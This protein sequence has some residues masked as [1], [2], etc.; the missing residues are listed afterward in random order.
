MTF[1]HVHLR[2][3]KP[4]S[5]EYPA[6]IQT[7]GDH[8]RKHRL[9]LSLLQKQVAVQIGTDNSTVT[10]WE[11]GHTSPG[12]RHF[13]AIRRFLGYLPIPENGTL[14]HKLRTHRFIR[15]WSQ[16]EAARDLRVHPSTLAKWER[17]AVFAYQRPPPMLA[18]A[19]LAVPHQ[20]ER[21]RG[22]AAPTS[23]AK[24]VHDQHR[25]ARHLACRNAMV[26]RCAASCYR[27][28]NEWI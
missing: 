25:P 19:I 18:C 4:P 7:I 2:G 27:S 11:L 10:T 8:I 17:G 3:Q 13:P 22:A 1:C 12:F 9:D 21:V 14:R 5:A 23:I 20:P 6:E 28:E 24:S 26:H 16:K 15:G